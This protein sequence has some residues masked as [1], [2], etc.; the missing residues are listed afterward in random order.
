MTS[1]AEYST[2][3]KISAKTTFQS[4][5]SINATSFEDTKRRKASGDDIE[6]LSPEAKQREVTRSKK[7]VKTYTKKINKCRFKLSIL[8]SIVLAYYLACTAM[9]FMVWHYSKFSSTAF[10]EERSQ[11][12]VIILCLTVASS[13]VIMLNLLL[14]R[15][16]KFIPLIITMVLLLILTLCKCFPDVSV[17]NTD[18]KALSNCWNMGFSIDYMAYFSYATI[19]SLS[20]FMLI[21]VDARYAQFLILRQKYITRIEQNS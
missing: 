1:N 19:C 21:A 4:K 18:L 7:E 13:L 14:V 2:Y 17:L 5:V 11:N 10:C 3:Q 16:E 6:Y 8:N 15:I 12:S 9:W 20:C